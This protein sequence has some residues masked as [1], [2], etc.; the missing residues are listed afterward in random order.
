MGRPHR[1]DLGRIRS[2]R[3]AC[4]QLTGGSPDARE[5]YTAVGANIEQFAVGTDTSLDY[6][7]SVA[8]GPTTAEDPGSLVMAKTADGENLYQLAGTG[9]TETIYQYSIDPSTGAPSPKSPA[10]V[11]TIALLGSEE[12]HFLAVFNP[13][14]SGEGGQNALY[15]LSG[16]NTETAVI[17]VFDIDPTS[18]ALTAAGEVAIPEM[19][20]GEALAY[21][22]N[23]LA[24]N[25]TTTSFDEGFQSATID[26][27]TGTPVFG[28]LP[29]APCPGHFCD[30]GSLYMLDPEQMLISALVPN[31][32]GGLPEEVDGVAAY[33]VGGAW[34]GLGS[35]AT[36]RGEIRE[37]TGNSH[38]YLVLERQSESE[39]LQNEET[40]TGETLVETFGSD[41][42]AG[43]Y[44]QLP[45]E[46]SR[47]PEGIFT[48]GSGLYF[49]NSSGAGLAYR[50]SAGQPPVSTELDKPLGDATA[51]FLGGASEETGSE[52]PGS[53]ET[54]SGKTGSEK[55]ADYGLTVTVAGSG[56]VTGTDIA[57][58]STCTASFAAGT[59][60][61]LTANPSPGSTFAGWGGA[62]SGGGA[63]V[64]TMSSARTVSAD[65]SAVPPPDTTI[66]SIKV[67]GTKATIK[68][69]GSGGYGPLTFRCK[70]GAAKKSTMCHSPLTYSHLVPG[71]HH[72]SVYAIDGRGIA[73]PTPAKASFKTK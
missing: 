21:S 56:Q 11:G 31:P 71:K 3:L 49:A 41:G 19:R 10:S 46:L 43:G 25:G 2:C 15:V 54:G 53:E 50:L 14:A 12:R 55:P 16:P 23:V 39:A 26:P 36:R 6:A 45:S 1:L 22:G 24:V 70:L 48:L 59:T 32:N 47:G 4:V 57:C 18:G 51:G 69:K 52:K 9:S 66:A 37:I 63:C 68:F 64:V 5:L 58:P 28:S 73:D 38:E 62:C 44:T 40:Y 13:A 30:G 29:D 17:Y 7:H 8:G 20:F 42:L 35:A 33:D 61:A 67:S 65:F 72:F 34:G 27:S 60:V